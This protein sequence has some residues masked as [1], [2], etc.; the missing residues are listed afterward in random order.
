MD[1]PESF[2]LKRIHEIPDPA[3]HLVAKPAPEA[4]PP[5]ER[6]LTRTQR[7]VRSLLVLAAAVGWVLFFVADLG[8]RP[9][10]FSPWVIVP[11]VLWIIAAAGALVLA[12]R[13]RER[14]LPAGVRAIQ[15]IVAAIP[16]LFGVTAMLWSAGTP[17]S[18]TLRGAGV[19]LPYSSLIASGPLV[20]ACLAFRR[21]FTS[22]A[23][24]RGAAVGAVCGLAGSIGIHS[25]CP[26]GGTLH[27]LIGHGVPIVAGAILGGILG[28]IRGRI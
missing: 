7:R 26:T 9:D 2:D 20:F 21:S 13:P 6:S 28:A 5:D 19:C 15:I 17:E 24:W 27:A 22:A 1:A 14:G 3:A 8:V 25:H 4:A 11:L 10:V 16:L 12:L 23:A 18:F